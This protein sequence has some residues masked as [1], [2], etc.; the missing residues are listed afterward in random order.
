MTRESGGYTVWL[1]FSPPCFSNSFS[2]FNS[3]SCPSFL[4]TS[5]DVI[6]EIVYFKTQKFIQD[7][8]YLFLRGR[9]R[10]RERYHECLE[11]QKEKQIPR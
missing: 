9:D 5:G 1:Y 8:I 10:E 11:G 4:D 6:L 7:F 3:L 2:F